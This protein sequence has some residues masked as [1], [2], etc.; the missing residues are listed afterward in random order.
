MKK[1]SVCVT[2]Y[3]KVG[4]DYENMIS[5]GFVVAENKEAAYKKFLNGNTGNNALAEGWKIWFHI[6]MEIPENYLNELILDPDVEKRTQVITT[7]Y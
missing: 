6:E 3:K 7:N 1:H 4:R 5:M 2:F